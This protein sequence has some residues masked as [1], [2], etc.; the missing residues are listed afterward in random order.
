MLKTFVTF[1]KIIKMRLIVQRVLQ[2][3]LKI[4]GEAY[5]SIGKGLLVLAGIGTD[6]REDMIPWVCNKLVN[7]RIFSDAEGKMN[8][9]V[10]DTGGEIM[11]VSNF[12]LYGDASKGFRPGFAAA[13][14]PAIS[15]PVYDKIIRYL[16]E[17]YDIPVKT[18]VFGADMQV[19][20]INDGPVTIIIEKD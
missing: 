6:D 16:R 20:L 12:T 8:L 18:G 9:S 15:E 17:N 19:G 10:K 11:L 7:L 2:A 5:S 3:E 1:S 4:N 14:A 13:A